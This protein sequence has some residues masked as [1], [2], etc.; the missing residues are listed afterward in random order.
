MRVKIFFSD[1]KHMEKEV[2]S[3]RSAYAVLLGV[4][5]SMHNI[6][7]SDKEYFTIHHV[8]MYQILDSD[9]FI[10]ESESYIERN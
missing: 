3:F 2:E 8:I 6:A 7:L 1:G 9:G 5:Q 4:F 10:I